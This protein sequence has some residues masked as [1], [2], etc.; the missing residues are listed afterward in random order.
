MRLICTTRVYVHTCLCERLSPRPSSVSAPRSDVLHSGG[1]V[2][3]SA[4]VSVPSP[5]LSPCAVTDHTS[6]R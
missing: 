3:S 1:P 6:D 4:V 5:H 2:P